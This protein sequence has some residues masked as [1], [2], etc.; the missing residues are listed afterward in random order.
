MNKI[1]IAIC[2]IIAILFFIFSNSDDNMVKTTETQSNISTDTQM[3]PST[4]NHNNEILQPIKEEKIIKNSEPKSEDKI[5]NNIDNS[6]LTLITTTSTKDDKYTIDIYSD[7]NYVENIIDF[8]GILIEANISD[9]KFFITIDKKFYSYKENNIS[10]HIKQNSTQ[11]IVSIPF[12]IKEL[13]EFVMYD[14]VVHFDDGF[15]DIKQKANLH[16]LKR[17]LDSMNIDPNEFKSD[18]MK[19]EELNQKMN[20]QKFDFNLSYK[21]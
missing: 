4:T 12:N 2:A 8:N 1:Y 13:E 19:I 18:T 16:Q 5:T 21:E 11:K 14:M 20:N 9:S 6:N 3:Q 7:G 17:E 15:F 10:L